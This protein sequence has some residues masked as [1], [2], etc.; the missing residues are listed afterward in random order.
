MNSNNVIRN[1]VHVRTIKLNERLIVLNIPIFPISYFEALRCMIYAIS[2][3]N[4]IK[5][6]DPCTC[7]NCK[8][9]FSAPLFPPTSTFCKI[10]NI[11]R[12]TYTNSKPTEILQTNRRYCRIYYTYP[13]HCSTFKGCFW[14]CG[15]F[16]FLTFFPRRSFAWPH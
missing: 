5:L 1:N 13:Y 11:F 10:K 14:F 3:D 8:R 4:N 6:F 7:I 9:N 12:E 15:V 2:N 16:N